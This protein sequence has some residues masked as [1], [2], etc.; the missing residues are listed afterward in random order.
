[1]KFCYVKFNLYQYFECYI[2]DVINVLKSIKNF[3][4]WFEEFLFGIFEC[5]FYVVFFYDIG[6][7]VLGF[8]KKKNKWG[9]CYEIFLVLFVQFLDFLERECNL[10]VFVILIYY[11]ILDE[12]EEIFLVCIDNIGFF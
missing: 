6:K 2:F 5:L 1:M 10:I 12:F 8:Q 3:F 11:K 7:C 9:Y 4:F